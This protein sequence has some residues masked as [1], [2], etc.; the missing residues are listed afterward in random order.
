MVSK[1]LCKRKLFCIQRQYT[2]RYA[3]QSRGYKRKLYFFSCATTMYLRPWSAENLARTCDCYKASVYICIRYWCGNRQ[4]SLNCGISYLFPLAEINLHV[5]LQRS[6]TAW[7]RAVTW[8]RQS[9]HGWLANEGEGACY[10]TNVNLRLDC[11]E[12]RM[13]SKHVHALELYNWRCGEHG[14][15]SE[16]LSNKI[17]KTKTILQPFFFQFVKLLFLEID[18]QSD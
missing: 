12:R 14:R 17:C 7:K 4:N 18:G 1:V 13:S 11:P 6:T 5:A 9:N 2:S 8:H 15:N 3:T 16:E 10:A